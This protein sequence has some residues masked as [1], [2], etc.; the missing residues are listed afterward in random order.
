MT[1]TDTLPGTVRAPAGPSWAPLAVL[2]TGTFMFV[3]DFFILNVALPSIQ[4]GLR[5]GE[6]ATEWIVAG[7]RSPPPCCSSP[8]GASVTGSAAGGCSASGWPSS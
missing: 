5:A 3:L 7:T 6:G 1:A 8:A 2:M 4:H